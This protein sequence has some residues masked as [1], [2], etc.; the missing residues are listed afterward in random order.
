MSIS[1]V[2]LRKQ[3]AD[4]FKREPKY[5]PDDLTKKEARCTDLFDNLHDC[6]QRHGWNDN[7]CQVVIKPK[8]DRCVIKRVSV[9]LK[10]MQFFRTKSELSCLSVT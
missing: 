2:G 7:Q 10:L 3:F 1:N 9:L 5:T 4:F 8:Y 6:V